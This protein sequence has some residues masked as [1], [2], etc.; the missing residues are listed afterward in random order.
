[1]TKYDKY[2]IARINHCITEGLTNSISLN[3]SSGSVYIS[4]YLSVLETISVKST[5][6]I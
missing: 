6:V 5:T 4:C 2:M 3:L 1:M